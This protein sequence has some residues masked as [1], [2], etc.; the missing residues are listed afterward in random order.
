MEKARAL[1]LE[2]RTVS[3]VSDSLGFEYP[4]SFTRMFKKE[5]G[6]APSKVGNR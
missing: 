4:Q 5:F 6:K 1:L 3:E 2:G